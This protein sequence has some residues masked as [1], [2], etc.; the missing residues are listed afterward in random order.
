MSCG[1]TGGFSYVYSDK[2]ANIVIS[3]FDLTEVKVLAHEMGHFW[4]LYHTFEEYQFGK[5]NFDSDKCHETG[6]L[7]CDT[8]PDP[9]PIYEVYVNYT[10]CELI[11][12]KD[13]DGHSYKPLIENYMS[14][15]KPC[16]LKEYSFTNDQVNVINTA[17]TQPIRSKYAR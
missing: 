1:R 2:T 7:I 3:K 12:F 17:L 15:Y 16:Y 6:D 9:G 10:D 8:P 4:G 13:E 14:Y 11:N 5:D